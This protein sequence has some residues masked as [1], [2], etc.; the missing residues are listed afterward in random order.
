METKKE[1]I[2][3]RVKIGRPAKFPKAED[4]WREA[5]AY[6]DWCDDNPIMTNNK[7]KK[8]RSE[9]S[10]SQSMEQEPV[11]RPYTL[12]GLCL[13]CNILTPWATFKRDCTRRSDAEDFAI[14][15]N[16]C[17]QCVRDQQVTGA[18]IGLYSER[19]TARLNGITDKQELEVNSRQTNITFDEYVRMLR[20]EPIEKK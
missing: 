4:L 15:I 20:G 14:V 17:E 19:L 1:P 12:D 6:F 18:I 2:Y 8:S 5:L 13:W 16:A 11:S 3:K 9:T 10:E 7:R